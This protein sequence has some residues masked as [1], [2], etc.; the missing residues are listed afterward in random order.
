M[1]LWPPHCRRA[2]VQW[3]WASLLS[4]P[5]TSPEGTFRDH[6]SKRTIW[7]NSAFFRPNRGQR[8]FLLGFK[9]VYTYLYAPHI[10][11]FLFLDNFTYHSLYNK[12]TISYL[13]ILYRRNL[14]THPSRPLP[15]ACCSC[16]WRALCHQGRCKV[17]LCGKRGQH[18]SRWRSRGSHHT[19]KSEIKTCRKCWLKPIQEMSSLQQEG[20]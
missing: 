2:P 14:W 15:V 7:P 13:G 9:H 3:P 19:A 10:G 16:W 4:L 18:A 8:A 12:K 1:A 20:L 17:L 5:L 6:K 11:I